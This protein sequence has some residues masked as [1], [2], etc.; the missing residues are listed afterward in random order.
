MRTNYDQS[1]VGRLIDQLAERMVTTFKPDAPLVIV[2]IRTRGEILAQRLTRILEPEPLG[3][4]AVATT[5]PVARS[6]AT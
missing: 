5:W 2:G 1:D 4:Q 6:T 3:P